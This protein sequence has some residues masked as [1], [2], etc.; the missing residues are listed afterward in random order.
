MTRWL[1]GAMVLSSIGFSAPSWAAK[2]VLELLSNNQGLTPQILLSQVE[3][4]YAGVICEFEIDVED[5]ELVYE[6][7]VINSQLET[8]T[9]FEFLAKDGSLI[10]Q[11]ISALEADDQD[12]LKAVLLMNDQVLTFSELVKQ[13]MH[14]RQAYM[15]E[16]QLDH[17][18]GISY[19]ELKLI[20]DTGKRTLA[21]DIKSQRPLPMLKW[22]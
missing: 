8:K 2:E 7:S 3:R 10:D 1:V 14:E 15:L 17:D 21:F 12:S 16:A 11:K 19:L 5:G 4:D 13:A 6:I 20:D 18:L 22:D 9:E